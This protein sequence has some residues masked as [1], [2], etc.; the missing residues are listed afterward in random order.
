MKNILL[1]LVF[2]PTLQLLAQTIQTD[3]SAIKAKL[4]KKDIRHF[5]LTKQAWKACRKQHFK[6]TSDYFKPDP[7]NISNP[8]LL[9]DSGYVKAYRVAAYKKTKHKRTILRVGLIGEIAVVGLT[10][11]LAVIVLPYVLKFK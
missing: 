7:T 6:P 5:Y 4:V 11:A 9:T 8:N 10:L 2:V 1:L 3:S